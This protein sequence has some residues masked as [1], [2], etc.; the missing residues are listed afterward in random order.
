MTNIPSTFT[1]YREWF[2]QT[3]GRALACSEAEF[4]AAL[5]AQPPTTPA[6]CDRLSDLYYLDGIEDRE[7]LYR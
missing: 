1:L 5:A 3:Y 7:G 2:K 4:N 6:N